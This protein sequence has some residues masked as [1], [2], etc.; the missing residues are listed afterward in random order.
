MI[1]TGTQADPYRVP[2][3]TH[4]MLA[5]NVS[6]VLQSV[7]PAHGFGF[8]GLTILLQ[9]RQAI[10]F[11]PEAN[12]PDGFGTHQS[13]IQTTVGGANVRT[14]VCQDCQVALAVFHDRLYPEHAGSFRPVVV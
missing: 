3:P 8:S 10:V 9:P 6:S 13:D 5:C 12:L 11:V 4:Q 2:L 7:A 14:N 1:G